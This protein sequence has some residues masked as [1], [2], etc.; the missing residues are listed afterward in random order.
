ML[1][2]TFGMHL[3]EELPR[4]F[5]CG[6]AELRSRRL[7]IFRH[8]PL[9]EAVGLSINLPVI[10]PPVVRGRDIFVDGALIDNLPVKAMADTGEGP[11]IAVD[12]KAAPH[13]RADAPDRAFARDDQ[14]SRPP[15]FG[16]TLSRLPQLGSENTSAAA[17]RYADLVIQ[18]R[19]E[20]VGL[21]SFDQLDIAREAGRAATREALNRA[22]E[23]LIA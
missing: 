1:H 19:P 3:I 17:R 20:G 8:G 12:V 6:S 23:S 13:R 9:W 16:E 11:I 2:R 7:E 21:L 18:P 10:G 15:S 14:P 22:P 4:S 5:I